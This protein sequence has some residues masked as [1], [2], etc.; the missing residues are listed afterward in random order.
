MRV[1]HQ[2]KKPPGGKPGG[3]PELT[4][5]EPDYDTLGGVWWKLLSTLKSTTRFSNSEIRNEGERVLRRAV[6]EGVLLTRWQRSG[7]GDGSRTIGS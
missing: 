6:Q 1:G 3:K 2:P 4:F 7:S 5:S